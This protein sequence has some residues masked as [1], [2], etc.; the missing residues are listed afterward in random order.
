MLYLNIV[1]Y[2]TRL[3]VDKGM[4]PPYRL[5]DCCYCFECSWTEVDCGVGRAKY[6]LSCALSAVWQSLSLAARF[7]EEA[8]R[9]EAGA[10]MMLATRVRSQ[11][12]RGVYP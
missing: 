12:K 1:H 4:R 3:R 7:F 8:S 5:A 6:P 11:K 2:Y 10:S 9:P